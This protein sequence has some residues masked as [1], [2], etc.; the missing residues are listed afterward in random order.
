MMNLGIPTILSA[1]PD[2]LGGAGWGVAAL[3]AAGWLGTT[4]V[5]RRSRARFE[6]RLLHS[7][8]LRRDHRV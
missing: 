4:L 5:R 6:Q 7:L 2:S 1:S 8:Q 3:L